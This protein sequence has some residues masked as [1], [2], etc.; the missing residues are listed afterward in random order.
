MA[1]LG[2][3][4]IKRRAQSNEKQTA[5]QPSLL[6]FSMQVNLQTT[7]SSIRSV[8]L[9]LNVSY[10]YNIILFYLLSYGIFVFVRNKTAFK[11]LEFSDICMHRWM[12]L[13]SC[14]LRGLDVGDVEFVCLLSPF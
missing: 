12:I 13:L 7:T 6:C 2:T 9:S 8:I 11:H 1:S 10:L 3:V 14:S 5:V 4:A